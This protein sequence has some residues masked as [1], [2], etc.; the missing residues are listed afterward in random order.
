MHSLAPIFALDSV[1]VK[2]H[3]LLLLAW[4]L[5]NQCSASSQRNNQMKLTHY[6][7]TKKKAHDSQIVRAKENHKLRYGGSRQTQAPGTNQRITA[8]RQGCHWV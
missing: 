2:T 3:K 5:S 1:V 6:G 8:F 4:R 7:D